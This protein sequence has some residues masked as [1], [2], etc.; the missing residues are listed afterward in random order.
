MIELE[1]NF[2]DDESKELYR[3]LSGRAPRPEDL[4][5]VQRFKNIYTASKGSKVSP[6]TLQYHLETGEILGNG[7]K[8]RYAGKPELQDGDKT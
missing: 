5:H 8:V 7:V 1:Y 3:Q 4:K 2:T 6:E